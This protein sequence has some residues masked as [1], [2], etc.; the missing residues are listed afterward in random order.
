MPRKP[1]QINQTQC[2]LFDMLIKEHQSG[3]GIVSSMLA[4]KPPEHVWRG[5]LAI[6]PGSLIERIIDEFDKKTDIPLEIPFFTFF[7]FFAGYLLHKNVTLKTEE[8]VVQTDIWTVLLAKSGSGKTFT[9]KSIQRGIPDLEDI[10]YDLYGVASTARFIEDIKEHDHKLFIRDEFAELYKQLLHASGPHAETKNV[11]LQLHSNETISRKRKK[12]KKDDD[13]DIIIKNPAI[14]FLGMTVL[15]SF[16]NLLTADDVINGFA[17]RFSFIIATKDPNK[18]MIDYPIYSINTSSWQK[19]W[20]KLIDSI[21]FNQYIVN[22]CALDAYKTSFSLLSKKELDESFYRRQLWKA[23]KYALIYHILTG[24]GDEEI[25]RP[26]AYGWAGRIAHLMIYDCLE[27]L[28]SHGVS[29]LGEKIEKVE[30]LAMRMKAEGKQLTIRAIIQRI[31]SIKS[32]AEA[33]AI[34]SMISGEYF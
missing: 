20:K 5:V 6:P 22:D 27:L 7:H 29:E 1:K 16:S 17:Q 31:R 24:H 28:H 11:F 23:H 34:A 3:G 9:A 26:E 25:I 19:E 2:S 21:K 33:K 30:A 4:V 12:R 14:S 13:E 32:V 8:S 10:C 15:Q 18:R